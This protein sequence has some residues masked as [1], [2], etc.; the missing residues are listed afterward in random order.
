[1]GYKNL[2]A[3][4]KSLLLMQLLGKGLKGMAIVTAL[5]GIQSI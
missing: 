2:V 1:M 5:L 4:Y 3:N